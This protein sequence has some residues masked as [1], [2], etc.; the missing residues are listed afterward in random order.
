LLAARS[1]D[2]T[3]LEALR[4]TVGVRA[5]NERTLEFRL[6]HPAPWFLSVLTTWCG[7]PTRE[8]LVQSAGTHWTE[9]STYVGNGPYVL[10]TWERQSHMVLE[11]NPHYHKG[12]PP[13][14]TVELSMIGDPATAMTAHLNG[15]LDAVPVPR[16][17]VAA[18][19][20]DPRLTQQYQRFPGGCV[21]YLGF[22]AAAPPFNRTLVRRAFAAA[23]DREEL[24]RGVLGG[25]GVPADQLV[26]AGLPGHFEG[27]RPQRYDV[28]QARRWLA[29]AGFPDG[30]GFP[31][32]RLTYA[33]DDRNQ[34][35]IEA[36][37]AQLR[38]SLGVTLVPD[39][40]EPRAFAVM[41]RTPERAPAAYVFGWCQDYPDP[42][43]WYNA[44][45]HSATAAGHTGWTDAEFDRLTRE[46]DGEADRS[47]RSDLYRRAAQILNDAAPVVFLYHSATARL[48]KPYVSGLLPNPLDLFEGQTNLFN[49]K[50]LRH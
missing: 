1:S 19:S 21:A 47:R 4:D 8:D 45:F 3:R 23:L 26:P 34:P 24:V 35:R 13:L 28:A 33:A 20:A 17:D 27:L 10:K 41:L 16:E 48:V 36:L 15:E 43:S 25:A 31:E 50:I 30:Q 2:P 5:R 42:R 39:P 22:N 44:A 32:V 14:S 40:V 38:R 12:P 11:T 7:L 6:T 46:A 49:L 29:E 9:P 18:I 37:I